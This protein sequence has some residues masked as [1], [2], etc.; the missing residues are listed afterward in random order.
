MYFALMRY[1]FLHI[2]DVHLGRHR[3]SGPERYADYFTALSSVIAYARREQVDA[4]LI[5]GDLFDEQEPSVETL[6]RAMET[7]RPLREAGV[8]VLA[9]E[10]NHD[11]RKRTEAAGALDL[12]D[13]EGYLRLLRPRF[14]N[15]TVLLDEYAKG[16]TGALWQPLPSLLIAGLG[17]LPHNIEEYIAQAA[18]Q[19]PTDTAVILLAHVMVTRDAGMPEYGCIALED[20]TVLRDR[21]TF[22]ALGHRHTRTGLRGETDGWVF[23]PGSLEYVHSLDYQQPADLRGFYDVTITDSAE[24]IAGDDAIKNEEDTT[25]PLAEENEFAVRRGTYRLTVRHVPTEKRPA[26]TLRVD[27][28][29]CSHPDELLDAV[30]HIAETEIDEALRARQP[31]LVVRLQGEA[32]FS[33]V[34]LPRAGIADMLQSE[35]NALHVEVMDRDL[36]AATDATML[37][38]EEDGL[39][40]VADRARVIA[41]E[42]LRVRGI[43]H[44][45]EAELSAVLIDLKKQ[46]QGT[47]KHPS[48]TVLE[49]MREQLQPFVESEDSG[50]GTGDSAVPEAE[51]EGD[52]EEGT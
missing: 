35:F 13:G 10:G 20:L 16:K 52:A 36:L 6:R 19:L 7:L 4:L 31:I 18:E 48:D 41:A 23:N 9:I 47:A 30:R 39:E 25:D 27:V 26:H 43:A 12:L 38:G 33:R 32:G 21:V 15:H 46:L 17:F 45:R 37:I 5:A 34:R 29:G 44:N 28:S 49:R 11:R 24:D 51:D 3:H 22:L 14:E 8:D 42:L 1:R 50:G 40:Q 2:A